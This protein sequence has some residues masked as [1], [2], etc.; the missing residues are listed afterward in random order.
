M[1]EPLFLPKK[2]TSFKTE[3]LLTVLNYSVWKQLRPSQPMTII[4]LYQRLRYILN[5]F[6]IRPCKQTKSKFTFVGFSH[7]NLILFLTFAS[8]AP[9]CFP[10]VLLLNDNSGLSLE[11]VN[12]IFHILSSHGYH[13]PLKRRTFISVTEGP[14]ET[15]GTLLRIP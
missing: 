10:Y 1:F 8:R 6:P 13:I 15:R 11:A 2:E 3:S 12:A 5:L 7:D 14:K 9:S 4:F